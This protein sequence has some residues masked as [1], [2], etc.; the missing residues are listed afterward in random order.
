MN[1]V[2]DQRP[3]RLPL[4]RAC[5]ALGLNRSTVYAH[6]Q[7]TAN[8]EPPRRSRKDSVQPRALSAQERAAV[9]ETLHSEPY[10]D[11]PPAEVYQRLLEQDQY[12]CSV[13]TMHRIL[14]SLNENGD[15]RQQRPAQHHAV[16][17]LLASAPHDVWTWDITKLPL[18]R[19]G[20]YLS[21][22]VVLVHIPAHREHPFWFNVN[23]YSGG[24]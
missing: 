9:V 5:D 16:P 3:S 11:Q 10:C 21:L 19:R 12:L 14:R 18:V 7:R 13:S 2:L 6:Q 17:R 4:T 20:I 22:Y 24:T 15:R 8:D 23:T 1:A